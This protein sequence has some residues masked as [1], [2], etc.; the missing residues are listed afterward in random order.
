MGS[1]CISSRPLLTFLLFI[2]TILGELQNDLCRTYLTDFSP[3][4]N[5]VQ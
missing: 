4:L 5:T 1:D 2:L 3:Q